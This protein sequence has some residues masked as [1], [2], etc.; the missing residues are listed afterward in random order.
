[1]NDPFLEIEVESLDDSELVWVRL[2][3]DEADVVWSIPS[4]W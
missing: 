1:M 2:E 3:S 4:I